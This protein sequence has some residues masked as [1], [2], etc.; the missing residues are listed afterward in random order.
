MSCPVG[1]KVRSMPRVTMTLM[2]IRSLPRAA[3]HEFSSLSLWPPNCLVAMEMLRQCGPAVLIARARCSDG[4]TIVAALVISRRT[5]C[6]ADINVNWS[7]WLDLNQRPP[8]SETGTLGR[9]ELHPGGA[10]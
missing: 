8:V 10:P 3:H 5:F 4:L 1:M 9:T 7:G 2:P 6:V